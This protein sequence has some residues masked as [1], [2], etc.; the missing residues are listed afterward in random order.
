ML[1]THLELRYDPLILLRELRR[2]I[3]NSDSSR[4]REKHSAAVIDDLE[5][6]LRC[7]QSEHKRILSELKAIQ[8]NVLKV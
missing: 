3:S 1:S 6:R 4:S 2:L 7:A 8:N 5:E